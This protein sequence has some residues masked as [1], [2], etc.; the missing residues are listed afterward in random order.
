MLIKESKLRKIIRQELKS[1]LNELQKYSD[2]AP[3]LRPMHQDLPMGD[4]PD[5]IRPGADKKE[6]YSFMRSHL[7]AKSGDKNI[8][9]SGRNMRKYADKKTL[10]QFR[11]WYKS[12]GPG[13]RAAQ[14]RTQKRKESEVTGMSAMD[15]IAGKGA[16]KKALGRVGIAADP[17]AAKQSRVVSDVDPKSL[18]P[19]AKQPTDV[20]PLGKPRLR[21]K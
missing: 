3:D 2:A 10:S 1:I 6:V 17:A 16:L 19:Q 18:V 14:K 21:N 15:K 20:A 8:R 12:T 5:V 11:K 13:K 4:L 9:L 7:Q